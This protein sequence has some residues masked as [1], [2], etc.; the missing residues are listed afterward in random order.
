MKEQGYVKLVGAGP[1]DEL[2]ITR[3]GFMALGDCEVLI[4]DSLASDAFLQDVPEDCEKIYV[5]KRCGHHSMKQEEINALLVKKALEG[6][7]VVRLKGGDPFVFGRG[8]EEILALQEHNISY[9]VIPGVTSAVAAPACAG[10][11]VTHRGISRSFHVITGHTAS[12]DN[13]L[14]DHLEVLA[15]LEGTLIFLMGLNHLS[16]IV[17]GLKINGKSAHTPVALIEN[18]TLPNQRRITGTLAT[19]VKLAKDYRVV[20]PAIIVIGEVA[21]LTMEARTPKN[22][23]SGLRIAVTGTPKM[24]KKLSKYLEVE[25]AYV[26]AYPYLE[27]ASN[28]ELL[29]GS[30]ERIDQYQWI[31]F[32][33]SN[34]IRIFFAH[35]QAK[36]IDIRKLAHMKFAVIGSGTEEELARYGIFADFV[37]SV[38]T[39]DVL[40]KEFANIVS[41]SERVLIPRAKQGS[42]E[43]TKILQAEKVMFD[44][45]PLYNVEVNKYHLLELQHNLSEYDYITFESS[46]GVKGFFEIEH[47]KELLQI[48]TP[49]C[50]GKVTASTLKQRGVDKMLIGDDNTLKGILTCL[51]REQENRS[52]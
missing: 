18:G 1:G 31:M 51:K 28:A 48:V 36:R 8:G 5:G 6:K 17:E 40:A 44:E 33:S 2:L 38:Y 20:S 35:L 34:G 10:I 9:E 50:I 16:A 29:N 41:K 3:K 32:T 13:S 42:K 24:T 25:G 15:K 39:S 14:T 4:Y 45:I 37:P 19:I 7:R 21:S 43:L 47:A 46:S 22:L 49:V 23:L 26:R 12:A 11:P 52:K 30:L 27:I